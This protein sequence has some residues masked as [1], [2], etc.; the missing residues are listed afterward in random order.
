MVIQMVKR[1][2]VDM[3]PGDLSWCLRKPAITSYSKTVQSCSQLL[4]PVSLKPNLV[5][6]LG[7]ISLS[8]S[9][10]PS[11][12]KY[13]VHLVLYDLYNTVHLALFC[14]AAVLQVKSSAFCRW[15]ALHPEWE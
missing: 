15:Q 3:E 1:F 4:R 7:H 14:V 8:H 11:V 6:S 9:L 12:L 10:S 5:V 2:L 13:P